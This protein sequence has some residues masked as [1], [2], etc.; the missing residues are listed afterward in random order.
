MVPRSKDDDSS[1]EERGGGCDSRPAKEN[2]SPGTL[3]CR[4]SP[5]SLRFASIRQ[6]VVRG[7]YFKDVENASIHATGR[8]GVTKSV[9]NAVD[10][11]V[12]IWVHQ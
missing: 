2:G 8:S 9:K 5:A 10:G 3:K 6:G 7:A 12:M 4:D 1:D 11:L